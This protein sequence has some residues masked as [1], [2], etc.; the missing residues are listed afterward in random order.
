LLSEDF[1]RAKKLTL[2]WSAILFSVSFLDLSIEQNTNIYF[3]KIGN[4]NEQYIKFM[5][6]CAMLYYLIYFIFV[7]LS[8]LPSWRKNQNFLIENFGTLIAKLQGFVD[9]LK[10]AR[11]P[12]AELFH[13]LNENVQTLS[14]QVTDIGENPTKRIAHKIEAKNWAIGEAF[15]SVHTAA[16]NAISSAVR[17]QG[18][19]PNP[20]IPS[21][22]IATNIKWEKLSLEVVESVVER[23]IDD[24]PKL[25][26]SEIAPVR[27]QAEKI[28]SSLQKA[29]GDIE[30]LEHDHFS[31]VRSIESDFKSIR[32][33]V[34]FWKNATNFRVYVLDV[35]VP[36]TF[37]LA[38]L[39]VFVWDSAGRPHWV[40]S[41]CVRSLPLHV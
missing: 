15:G 29:R 41:P 11:L 1:S 33:N 37:G 17:A 30:Y 35:F 23:I 7:G 31:A 13:K 9:G 8:E 21:S 24:V 12:I 38:S 34:A 4:T 32:E 26:V 39:V 22:T 36:L 3:F 40:T 2:A 27:E 20:S 25:L 18:K 6:L 5:V 10:E 28:L 16:F 14:A 19:Q